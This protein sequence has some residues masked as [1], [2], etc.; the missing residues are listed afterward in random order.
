MYFSTDDVPE[1]LRPVLDAVDSQDRV[2]YSTS[3]WTNEAG[4]TCHGLNVHLDSSEGGGASFQLQ[5]VD[6]R[7]EMCQ[8]IS[9]DAEFAGKSEYR[10]IE[11][12][13]TGDWVD[14]ILDGPEMFDDAMTAF[15]AILNR[16]PAAF[17]ANAAA[18]EKLDAWRRERYAIWA[19]FCGPYS[20]S[21]GLSVNIVSDVHALSEMG[22]TF[23]NALMNESYRLKFAQSCCQGRDQVFRVMEEGKMVANGA[24]GV[25]G[26]KVVPIFMYGMHNAT[27]PTDSPAAEA[28]SEFL[29]AVNDG[30]HPTYMQLSKSGFE[31]GSY[32]PETSPRPRM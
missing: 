7:I 2:S 14:Y 5:E 13:R 24:L 31:V 6:G 11:N 15:E 3:E 1:S 20:A 8:Y 9:M 16:A 28:F 25:H 27:I 12:G 18:E 32:A 4:I 10:K 21:N 19:P 29:A 26:G 17:R 30:T 22:E 23:K